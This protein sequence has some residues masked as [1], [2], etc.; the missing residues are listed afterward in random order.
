MNRPNFL[1]IMSDQHNPHLMGHAGEALVRTPNLDRLAASG[2]SF[3]NNYCAGPLCVPSRMTFM[4]GQYPN[5]LQIWTN[6]G[7]LSSDVPTFAHSLSLAGWETT[8]CGRMHFAGSDQ[9]HGFERRL[10]GDVSGAMRGVPSGTFEGVWSP[11]GCGQSYE[12]LF[13]DAVGPGQAAYAAYDADVTQ[14]AC[15]FLREEEMAQP[16][17]LLVGMLLPHNPYVCPRDLFEEYM[18]TLPAPEHVGEVP[19]G[20]HPAALELRRF[21]GAD[22]ITPEQA[23]RARAAY[24]GLITLMDQNIGRVLDTLAEKGLAEDAV[25][26]YTSDHGDL[27]GE[28]SLWWKDS[29]YEGSAGV[30]MIWSWPGRFRTNCREDAVTGLLDVGPTL[31]ELAGAEPLPGA[32]GTSLVPLL[33]PEGIVDEWPDTVFA[34]TYARGQR[35]AR[36]IRSGR[37]KLNVYHGYDHPQ[38]FDMETDPDEENDLGTDPDY[39]EVR[40]ELMVRVME[41]W[42]GEWIERRTQQ[43]AEEQKLTRRWTSEKRV[44]ES[45]RWIMREG[46][47]VREP[48]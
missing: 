25:V 4:T 31:T 12:G 10:V 44:R 47:N 35:P 48:E 30:P 13:D 38:L 32:R 11:A 46:M 33:D 20:E 22:R 29:F 18:D 43:L 41:G 9:H 8:L 27:A 42:S 28:H 16:F 2:V 23:R 26:V 19:V 6:G 7:M 15:A 17:C 5:D 14:R 39:A 3:A 36:M 45:E 37:W 24:F 40:R 34:E 21:R 1:I